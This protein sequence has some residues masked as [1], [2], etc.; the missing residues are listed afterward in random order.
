[1][2]G[3]SDTGDVSGK[4]LRSWLTSAATNIEDNLVL[5][6]VLVVVDEVAVRIGTDGILEHGLV[7]F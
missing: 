7:D 5:E 1:M 2:V 3:V 4:G 6:E